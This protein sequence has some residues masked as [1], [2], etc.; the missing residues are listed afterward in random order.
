LI[1]E[2]NPEWRDLWK[3]ILGVVPAQAGT[4][5][6]PEVERPPAGG[7]SESPGF[8]PSRE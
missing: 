5:G 6:S 1:E 3:E 2:R 8:P 7:L 4:Q